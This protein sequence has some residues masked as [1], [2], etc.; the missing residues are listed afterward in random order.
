MLSMTNAIVSATVC[1]VAKVRL[2]NRVCEMFTA[3]FL[4]SGERRVFRLLRA[5]PSA[6]R[7]IGQEMISIGNFSCRVISLMTAIC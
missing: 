6:S 4:C 3:F 1:C 7:T 2:L 5:I